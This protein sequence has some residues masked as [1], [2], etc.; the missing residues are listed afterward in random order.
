LATN[1]S[2]E[3][4]AGVTIVHSQGNV[5]ALDWVLAGH[6]KNS[7]HTPRNSRNVERALTTAT[8][9]TGVGDYANKYQI[10]LNALGHND[11]DTLLAS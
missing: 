9:N 4:V 6:K 1:T 10:G 2:Q 3:R 7:G 8:M 5:R 11:N